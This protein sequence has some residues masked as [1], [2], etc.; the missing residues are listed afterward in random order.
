MAEKDFDDELPESDT[1][2]EKLAIT[3]D[4]GQEPLRID[5]FLMQRIEGAT[6]NKI[7][8]SVDN[9]LVL[10]NEKPVKNNYK[11]KA[12]DKIVIFATTAP[13]TSDILPQNIPL[14]ILFED[15]DILIIN[16]PV[17]MVVHPGSGNPDGT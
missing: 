15:D 14:D 12:G 3:I 9:E 5:K 8:Q 4:R 11:V 10:V 16:K 13:E 2:Y 17:G 6:R 1:L 7:Q